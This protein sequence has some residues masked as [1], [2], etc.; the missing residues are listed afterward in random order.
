[1]FYTLECLDSLRFVSILP[2]HTHHY[3]HTQSHS[4]KHLYSIGSLED[5]DIGLIYDHK[6]ESKHYVGSS[7]IQT[8]DSS[9]SANML[10]LPGI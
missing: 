8:T 6:S 1:M 9:T 7:P 2:Q 10:C 4:P 3:C 5:D